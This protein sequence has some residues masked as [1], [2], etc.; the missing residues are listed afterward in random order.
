MT[1]GAAATAMSF[2][3]QAEITILKQDTQAGNLLSRLNLTVGGSIR[4]I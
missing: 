2:T 3:T 4:P 1:I